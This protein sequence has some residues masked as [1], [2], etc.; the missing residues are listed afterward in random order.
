MPSHNKKTNAVL[1]YVLALSFFLLLARS[2]QAV[3]LEPVESPYRVGHD[4]QIVCETPNPQPNEHY[5]AFFQQV[6][7]YGYGG[8]AECGSTYNFPEGTNYLFEY[9]LSQEPYPETYTVQ[10]FPT[11]PGYIS[12]FS[13]NSVNFFETEPGLWADESGYV[14]YENLVEGLWTALPYIVATLAIFWAVRYVLKKVN[15]RAH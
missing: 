11:S 4:Y 14:F 9:A 5:V 15:G 8:S 13:W 12:G 2:A 7:Q 3:T 10:T 1:A 6:S